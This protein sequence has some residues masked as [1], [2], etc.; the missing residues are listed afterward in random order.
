MGSVVGR[1]RQSQREMGV[2]EAEIRHMVDERL[3][4]ECGRIRTQLVRQID[5]AL[6]ELRER[7]KWELAEGRVEYLAE[8]E[9]IGCQVELRLEQAGQLVEQLRGEH[10]W[11]SVLAEVAH[12]SFEESIAFV[13][14]KAQEVQSQSKHR[15]STH[16]THFGDEM[17]LCTTQYGQDAIYSALSDMFEALWGSPRNQRKKPTPRA[18]SPAQPPEP[19]LLER[20]VLALCLLWDCTS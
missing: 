17:Q 7:A 12:P 18:E 3:G 6:G 15:A 19:S 9:E 14:D 16:L 2:A 1:L 11:K 20:W 4:E 5:V 10:R 13:V 8:L